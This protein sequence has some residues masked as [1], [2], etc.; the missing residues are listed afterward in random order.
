MLATVRTKLLSGASSVLEQSL[1]R[2]QCKPYSVALKETSLFGRGST[3]LHN[4]GFAVGLKPLRMDFPGPTLSMSFSSDSSYNS[5]K[6]NVA[7]RLPFVD[8]FLLKI[9]KNKELL[10]NRKIWSRR[11][12]ILPEFVGSNVRIY[13][14]KTFVRCKITE[15]KVG[16]KFGEFAYTRKRRHLRQ[17]AAAAAA[18]KKVKKKA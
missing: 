2:T 4:L 3:H 16:H 8:A 13:N 18:K 14:G 17:S 15:T 7:T 11:S 12:V 6:K 10:A 1:L 9:K 5:V